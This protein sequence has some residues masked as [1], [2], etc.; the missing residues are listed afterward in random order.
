MHGNL[1]SLPPP[2][3]NRVPPGQ[4]LTQGFPVLTYGVTPQI[5]PET[6]CLWIWGLVTERV[7]RWADLLALP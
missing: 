5:T 6:W 2:S 7:V 3:P 4:H 1:P